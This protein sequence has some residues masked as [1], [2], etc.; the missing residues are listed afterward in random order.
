MKQLARVTALVVLT[1]A[2][3]ALVWMFSSAVLLFLLSLVVAAA[4]RPFA[5]R[6]MQRGLRRSLAYGIVYALI[7]VLL[8]SLLVVITPGLLQEIQRA[9]DSALQAY[10]RILVNW[11][12]GRPWQRKIVPALPPS[13][14]LIDTLAGERGS[15]LFGRVLGFSSGLFDVLAQL[16]VALSL[17]IYWA[18][19]QRRFER[20]WLSLISAHER[21]RARTIWRD[22]EREV[23][24]YV[25]SE[26]SQSLLA[27]VSLGLGYYFIGLPYPILLALWAALG[28]LIPWVGV[29]LAL[30]PAV[31]V[32]WPLGIVGMIGAALLTIG[33][34]V[35][36]EV[37]VE[38]RLYGRSRV[39][40]VLVVIVLMIM[41]QY[42]GILGM[43]LAPPLAAATQILARSL[44]F[45]PV[46]RSQ[47]TAL[48]A[49]LVD[50]RTRLA[51]LR[52]ESSASDEINTPQLQSLFVHTEE[53]LDK[54][55][56]TL[57]TGG[58]L[59]QVVESDASQAA[60]TA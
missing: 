36:M 32:A 58:M 43:L 39:S 60:S 50:L 35:V 55:H 4:V 41:A 34:F 7:V 15:A 8:A 53:L 57:A 16:V 37:W 2:L 59:V 33:V 20:L 27:G 12:K 24:D 54:T 47:P 48:L 22:V 30:I 23:G 14:A 19:D 13:Q 3:V 38:P 29:L 10:S 18:S 26:V 40:P 1:L 45:R 56:A 6:L 25:R 11:P 52:L 9:S 49:Q 42:A 17:S 46:P 21:P 28:W 51:H 31:L 44:W 5:V